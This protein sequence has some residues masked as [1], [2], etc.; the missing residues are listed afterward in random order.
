MDRDLLYEVHLLSHWD[1]TAFVY[2]SKCSK[3]N[4]LKRGEKPLNVFVTVNPGSLWAPLPPPLFFLFF[5]SEKLSH[6][7]FPPSLKQLHETQDQVLNGYWSQT[8]TVAAEM[9]STRG[10][11]LFCSFGEKQSGFRK[12][13]GKDSQWNSDLMSSLADLQILSW[14]AISHMSGGTMQFLV[15]WNEAHFSSHLNTWQENWELG[16]MFLGAEL[17]HLMLLPH[18]FFSFRIQLCNASKNSPFWGSWW[19]PKRSF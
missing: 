16:E 5:A 14:L 2:R 12:K 8:K 10:N 3:A 13:K 1:T 11:W 6:N 9:K 19:C 4:V 7:F 15:L 18:L 17:E